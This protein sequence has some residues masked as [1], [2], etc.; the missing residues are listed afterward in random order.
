MKNLKA[1]TPINRIIKIKFQN[2][3]IKLI[4]TTWTQILSF[5]RLFIN[6]ANRKTGVY[7]V[8]IKDIR[9]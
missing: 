4:K 7:Q 6:K 9:K 8:K 1:I 2:F 5:L 3:Q